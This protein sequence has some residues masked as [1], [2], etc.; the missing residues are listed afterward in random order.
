LEGGRVETPSEPEA[1]EKRRE[2]N[3]GQFEIPDLNPFSR[4]EVAKEP[5]DQGEV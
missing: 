1:I 5:L 2:S 4:R 3:A